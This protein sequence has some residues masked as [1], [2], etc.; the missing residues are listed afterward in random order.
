[1]H[2]SGL[3][4]RAITSAFAIGAL[5]PKLFSA[6]RVNLVIAVA[7]CLLLLSL[8]SRSPLLAVSATATVC[9]IVSSLLGLLELCGWT[10]GVR[11]MCGI[12]VVVG[13]SFDYTLHLAFAFRDAPHRTREA[14][15]AFAAARMGPTLLGGALTTLGSIVFMFGSDFP[16]L[17]ALA[18]MLTA[19]VIL[20]MIYALLFFLPLCAIAG[21]AWYVPTVGGQT[22]SGRGSDDA[23]RKVLLAPYR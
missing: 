10:L 16:F 9:A 6:L 22:Q 21:P 20:S 1:M 13:F 8:L 3:D 23:S 15:V 18:S 17:L 5:Y 2:N 14:R 11:E 4:R 19:C 12:A 7:L